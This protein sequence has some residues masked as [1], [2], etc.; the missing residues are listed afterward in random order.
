MASDISWDNGQLKL[1]PDGNKT[2]AAEQAFAVPAG[3]RGKRHYL[4]FEI[5]IPGPDACE[6]TVG[7]ASGAKDVFDG[8]YIKGRH[9]AT[10][11][12]P[13]GAAQ[14]FLRFTKRGGWPMT[15]DN[16]RF[17][18]DEP[19]ELPTEWGEEDLASLTFDQVYD[20]MTI[21]DGKGHPK[22]LARTGPDAFSLEYFPALDGPY[23]DENAFENVTLY[24]SAKDGANVQIHASGE[25]FEAADVGRHLT[26]RH[27]E[28]EEVHNGWGI[29]Q[30][31]VSPTQAGIRVWRAFGASGAASK[32]P[33]WRLGS[34]APQLGY[35]DAVAYHDGRQHFG[36]GGHP[37][38]IARVDGSAQPGFNRFTPGAGGDADAWTRDIYLKGR[39]RHLVSGRQLFALTTD[40][41]RALSGDGGTQAV[42]PAAFSDKPVGPDGSGRPRPVPIGA[43]ALYIAKDGQAVRAIGFDRETGAYLVPDLTLAAE[44]IARPRLTDIAYLDAPW[45]MIPLRRSD[46]QL[47]TL[48]YLPEMGIQGWSRQRV[49]DGAGAVES[50]ATRTGP[51]GDELWAVVRYE[52]NGLEQRYIERL[53]RPLAA[54]APDY[55]GF[56][57]DSGKTFRTA[58]PGTLT[59]SYAETGGG[60]RVF[61][62]SA[63]VFE[64]ADVGK[65]LFQVV[66]YAPDK[67]GSPR[68]AVVG[69]ARISGHISPT[70]VAARIDVAFTSTD[71]IPEGDWYLADHVLDGLSHLEGETVAVYA[72]GRRRSDGRVVNGALDIGQAAAI[73]HVGRPFTW[74]WTTLPLEVRSRQGTAQ[75]KPMKVSRATARLI[76]TGQ[77]S[78]GILGRTLY[79]QRRGDDGA[80]LTGDLDVDAG[81]GWE[82]QTSLVLSGQTGPAEVA[83]IVPHTSLGEAL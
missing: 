82:E 80:L 21:C 54:D 44:T 73:V 60:S 27:I 74:T 56:Y 18:D 10:F 47:P 29:I 28:N 77:V 65:T 57:V 31:I 14:L 46:G 71:P 24:A 30:R 15:V 37:E 63:N 53:E 58:P 32:T 79:E 20:T 22:D 49:A 23:L 35:P 40:L 42:T 4:Y 16:V 17:L 39:M 45:K 13:A 67:Y 25:F 19:I 50:I 51:G 48:T 76:R 52:V 81:G 38:T 26:I 2:A 61:T 3:D 36:G 9:L 78:A 1:N 55:E 11:V 62:A 68:D 12:T 34:W 64:A 7:T 43:G 59:P 75:G 8:A 66:R 6:V 69:A 70:R 5:F 83:L 41:V 72:D 33:A